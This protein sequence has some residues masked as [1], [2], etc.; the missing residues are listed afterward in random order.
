VQQTAAALRDNLMMLIP[1]DEILLEREPEKPKPKP[2][3]IEEARKAP[4]SMPSPVIAPTEM[5]AAPSP[6]VVMEP[7]MEKPD[8]GPIHEFFDPPPEDRPPTKLEPVASPLPDIVMRETTTG[9]SRPPSGIPANIQQRGEVFRGTGAPELD[10]AT[11][12]SYTG[13][14]NDFPETDK[15]TIGLSRGEEVAATTGMPG[16]A[17]GEKYTSDY[18]KAPGPGK[19]DA[20]LPSED[21][22]GEGE[23]AGLLDWLRGH[24]GQF[25]EV[26]MSY[27]ETSPNDL[28]GVTRFGGWDIFIQFSEDD[29][30]LKLFLTQGSTGILLADSDFKQRSQ[31]FGMAMVNRANTDLTAITAQRGKPTSESTR[32]FYTVFQSWLAAEGIVMGERAGR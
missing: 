3:P 12:P 29:H 20:L 16:V 2:M 14:V 24:R 17:R 10:P 19:S 1:L 6:I 8:F 22:L 4:R 25:P 18:G 31:L 7:S 26:L 11:T 30:Q 28:K 13:P 9:E 23:L 27:M 32:D 21:L 15:P 5:Q